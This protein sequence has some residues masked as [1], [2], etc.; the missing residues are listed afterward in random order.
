MYMVVTKGLFPKFKIFYFDH[1]VSLTSETTTIFSWTYISANINDPLTRGWE[2][3]SAVLMQNIT[4]LSQVNLHIHPHHPFWLGVAATRAFPFVFSYI[5]SLFSIVEMIWFLLNKYRW[6]LWETGSM[7][8]RGSYHKYNVTVNGT[9]LSRMLL[10]G[11]LI[12][13]SSYYIK[14]EIISINLKVCQTW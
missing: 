9:P 2:E 10:V 6:H 4:V 1:T 12:V 13:V 7:W 8:R 14:S 5:T 11:C 3:I